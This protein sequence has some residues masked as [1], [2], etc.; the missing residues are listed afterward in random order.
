M[1][2]HC[3]AWSVTCAVCLSPFFILAI[4][5]AYLYDQ[6]T[7][8]W[9]PL[10]E[11][12]LK[13]PGVGDDGIWDA[14][15]NESQSNPFSVR[16]LNSDK[17]YAKPE[18]NCD[19]LWYYGSETVSLE[20]QP[21]WQP[22]NCKMASYRNLSNLEE[23]GR[24]LS[25]KRKKRDTFI[26]LIGDSRMRQLQV[27]LFRELT[28]RT[29]TMQFTTNDDY[30]DKPE[31]LNLT[32]YSEI[33]QTC[34]FHRI[35]EP[36]NFRIGRWWAPYFSEA[37]L[38]GPLRELIALPAESA[39]ALVLINSGLWFLKDCGDRRVFF[40][41]CFNSYTKNLTILKH[42]LIQLTDRSTVVWVLQNNL[43]TPCPIPSE[44]KK[45]NAQLQIMN[46]AAVG[47]FADTAV[48]IWRSYTQLF[49]YMGSNGDDRHVGDEALATEVQII[50]NYLCNP[51]TQT[52]PGYCCSQS[53]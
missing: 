29:E 37:A 4:R 47:I 6:Q 48:K 21:G 53:S 43:A 16:D 10:S 22:F 39:P 32:W 42:E 45:T 40:E 33:L 34:L 17:R 18:T 50:L 7:F 31:A 52:D 46:D 3:N 23:C 38:A 28:G 11:G 13:R 9:T 36:Y 5:I 26:L 15:A 35:V 12:K 19:D 25:K 20:D 30:C 1:I 2:K 14:T 49:D 8:V 51:V 44:S 24:R 41:D 27:A